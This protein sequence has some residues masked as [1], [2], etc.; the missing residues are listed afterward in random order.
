MVIDVFRNL[1]LMVM[2]RMFSHFLGHSSETSA[3]KQM[4]VQ[5]IEEPVVEVEAEEE[6]RQI[7]CATACMNCDNYDDGRHHCKKMG[8]P[9]PHDLSLANPCKGNNFTLRVFK[10]DRL[11]QLR[12]MH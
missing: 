11:A 7:N 8:Y 4:M 9:I 10:G 6:V 12:R 5:A 2:F 3:Q 1:N